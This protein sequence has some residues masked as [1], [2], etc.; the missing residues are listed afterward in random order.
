MKVVVFDAKNESRECLQMNVKPALDEASLELKKSR[1]T[2]PVFIDGNF[3][4]KSIKELINTTA[5]NVNPSV[6][7]S[8]QETGWSGTQGFGC[9]AHARLVGN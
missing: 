5:E 7:E 6:F 2:M 1:E 3:Q 8:E 4:H 9:R